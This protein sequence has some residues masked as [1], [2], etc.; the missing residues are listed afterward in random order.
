M[1]LVAVSCAAALAACDAPVPELVSDFEVGREGLAVA[2]DHV[3]VTGVDHVLYEVPVDGGAP[4]ALANPTS[5]ELCGR[6]E[7]IRVDGGEVFWIQWNGTLHRVDLAT[8]AGET[9]DTS[10]AIDLSVADGV[11][12]WNAYD[13]SEPALW[14]WPPGGEPQLALTDG[15]AFYFEVAGGWL[16]AFEGDRLIRRSLDGV[17][18]EVLHQAG[19]ASELTRVVIAAGHAYFEDGDVTMRVPV[20]GGAAEVVGAIAWRGY[21]V[22]VDEGVVFSSELRLSPGDDEAER[23][24]PSGG[25]RETYV[26]NLAIDGDSLYWLARDA[27]QYARIYRADKAGEPFPQSAGAPD[28]VTPPFL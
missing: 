8:G 15:P 2:A 5:D 17:T 4:R 25:P 13:G 10:C 12:Y 18:R 3:Y 22:L 27:R 24:L 11:V 16:Y 7:A 14:V 6:T 9:A 21:G 23:F 26:E 1:R 20:D 28:T 19:S